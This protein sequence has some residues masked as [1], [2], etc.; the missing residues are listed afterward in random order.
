MHPVRH[1]HVHS[2]AA[3]AAARIRARSGQARALAL[4]A[5]VLGITTA[6]VTAPASA[7]TSGAT[8][9]LVS[10][11]HFDPFTADSP[12]VRTLRSTPVSGWARVLETSPDTA[13]SPY[14]SD[15]DYPLLRSAGA[16]IRQRA[17]HPA[18][19][20]ITGDFLGHNFE[21]KYAAVF[22]GTPDSA[23]AAT[24]AD[25]TMAFMAQF[26]GSLGPADVPIY[27]SIGNNDSGCNDYGMS[28]PCF[29]SAA[30]RGSWPRSTR[31]ATTR[32]ARPMPASR[33]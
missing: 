15:S 10:D 12:V 33:W 22:A 23:G 7:Q 25:S 19:V 29:R 13:P 21:Q 4:C 30:R 26:V 8:V 14:G 18:F 27:P 5:A 11:F 1:V 32:R 3:T 6:E 20:V 17:P 9:L 2:R 31:G 24:F 28:P 16:A